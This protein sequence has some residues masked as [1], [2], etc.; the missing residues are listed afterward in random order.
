[1][2]VQ[3]LAQEDRQA[4]VVVEEEVVAETGE[5]AVQAVLKAQLHHRK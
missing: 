2:R 5:V 1:M 4:L 3:A